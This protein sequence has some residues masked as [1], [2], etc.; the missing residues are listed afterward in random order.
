MS[1]NGGGV[2]PRVPNV[3]VEYRSPDFPAPVFPG[4]GPHGADPAV[5][6]TGGGPTTKSKVIAGVVIAVVVLVI[7]GSVAALSGGN[8]KADK[9]S[10]VTVTSA[11]ESKAAAASIPCTTP[12]V[13]RLTSLRPLGTETVATIE[14]RPSCDGSDTITSDGV[15]IL[16]TQTA[17]TIAGARFD[18]SNA[19]IPLKEGRS[20][21]VELRY[22]PDDLWAV[23]DSVVPSQT[24]VSLTDMGTSTTSST[25]PST[26][27]TPTTPFIPVAR[28]LPPGTTADSQAYAG[29]R[30]MQ[31]SDSASV[32]RDVVDRW[33]PQL[34]SKRVGLVADGITWQN[35][36][37]LKAQFDYR[38][39]FPQSR[40]LW[41]GDWSSFS[42]TDWWVTVVAMP[43]PDAA[44]ANAWCD[45][46]SLDKDHCFAKLVTNRGGSEQTTV[47]RR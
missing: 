17:G 20:T 14:L 4:Q 28:A 42:V 30:S 35:T 1:M 37:I 22:G 45:A 13:A 29:L 18:F 33:V 7:G 9:G 36:D 40:L 12:P 8:D 31:G 6:P 15:D 24:T 44:G 46:Q 27:S 38:G 32:Q 3:P 16:I 47:Y 25:D 2:D 34:S 10:G 19:P 26:L 41:S 11:G 43:F 5:P 39:R 21:T 23:P